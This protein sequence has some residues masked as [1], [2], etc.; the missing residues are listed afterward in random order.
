MDDETGS[1]RIPNSTFR[2]SYAPVA[3]LDRALASEAKGRG[4]DSR[5]A[6]QI[7][8]RSLIIVTIGREVSIG[9]PRPQGI[10]GKDS[11][12]LRGI[13]RGLAPSEEPFTGDGVGPTPARRTNI[14]FDH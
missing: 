9:D 5:Q 10:Q 6:H 14:I 3:Q 2:I 13:L 7:Y 4:S 1:F 12:E 8:I 11:P